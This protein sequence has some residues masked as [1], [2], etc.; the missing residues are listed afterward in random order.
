[1]LVHVIYV[2]T[3]VVLAK[4]QKLYFDITTKNVCSMSKSRSARLN[5]SVEITSRIKTPASEKC[6]KHQGALH[7]V[8]DQSVEYSDVITPLPPPHSGKW[9]YEGL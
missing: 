5:A 7:A 6:A 2:N 4:L 8:C 1:M 9:G 3:G